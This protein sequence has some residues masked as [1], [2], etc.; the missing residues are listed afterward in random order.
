MSPLDVD[1]LTRRVTYWQRRAYRAEH[2]SKYARFFNRT[3]NLFEL[4]MFIFLL[5]LLYGRFK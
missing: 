1:R 3:H 5:T 4:I 2:D